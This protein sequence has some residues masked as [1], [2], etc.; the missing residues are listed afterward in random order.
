[1]STPAF[2]HVYAHTQIIEHSSNEIYFGEN[3]LQGEMWVLAQVLG[4]AMPLF[5]PL[6][7]H[8]FCFLSV[9][10]TNIMAKTN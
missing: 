10:V 9:S 2:T 6:R 4:S 5:K 3:I 7:P 8:C 1:M